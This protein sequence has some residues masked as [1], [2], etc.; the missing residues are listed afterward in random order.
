MSLHQA[1][2]FQK[3]GRTEQFLAQHFNLKWI[4]ISFID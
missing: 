4:V 3:P 2:I 1:V